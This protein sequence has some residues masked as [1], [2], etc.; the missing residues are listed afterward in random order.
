MQI[1]IKNKKI[2]SLFINLMFF[3]F[4]Y[5]IFGYNF[6]T[7]DDLI[8][9]KLVANDYLSVYSFQWISYLCHGLNKLLP[10]IN[11][12][13]LLLVFITYLS[14]S[15]LFCFILKKEKTKVNVVL[16]SLY[17]LI[18]FWILY[19][20][21]F[22]I[23]SSLALSV[24]TLCINDYIKCKDKENLIVG[25][26]LFV[27]GF[28]IRKEGIVFILP[29][30]AL[31]MFENIQIKNKTFFIKQLVLF[32][33]LTS[34]LTISSGIDIKMYPEEY[35]DY[36]KFN[37][38]R[39]EISDK[40]IDNLPLIQQMGSVS[41]NDYLTLGY[42]MYNDYEY[43]TEERFKNIIID[44]DKAI[45]E[46]QL[47]VWCKAFFT[48][49]HSLFISSYFWII[50]FLLFGF[51]KN[52]KNHLLILLSMIGFI[53]VFIL[54]NRIAYR[55]L[56]GSFLPLIVYLLLTINKIKSNKLTPSILICLLLIVTCFSYSFYEQDK[57]ESNEFIHTYDYELKT[58]PE[59]LYYIT[60]HAAIMEEGKMPVLLKNSKTHYGNGLLNAWVQKHP[61]ETNMLN[62]FNIKNPLKE[63]PYKEK[64]YLITDKN[65]QECYLISQ[66]HKEHYN[67]DIICKKEKESKDYIIWTLKEKGE[68]NE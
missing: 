19:Q 59:N 56:F 3:V 53:V 26:I 32:G 22:T 48:V 14:C 4:V 12:W 67:T 45:N 17:F 15:K 47:G 41:I 61:I 25:I 60:L 38:L 57:I 65:E 8:Y 50:L 21:Q 63:L 6:N 2:Q 28:C 52:K 5:L 42:W 20:L 39:T 40:R 34:I 49:C 46:Q 11:A 44:L 68:N 16:Y 62:E 64:F 66:W 29:L 1:I 43:M 18:V 36:I 37:D 13:G 58:N 7:L 27:F 9:S 54:I 30:I 35:K 10:S 51:E 23:V 31:L 33:V 24:G 55:T